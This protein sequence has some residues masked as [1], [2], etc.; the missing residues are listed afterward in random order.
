MRSKLFAP[1]VLLTLS[2]SL[3]ADDA[4]GKASVSVFGLTVQKPGSMDQIPFFNP[5]TTLDVVIGQPGKFILGIDAK[6]SKLT[7]F[8]DDK[9]T[10][11]TKTKSAFPRDW[12]N[13]SFLRFNK[14]NT[15]CAVQVCAPS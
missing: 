9:K 1:V 2:G 4:K 5:G 3:F 14:D 12:L 6:A 15:Q 13:A 8:T 10:D 11:L 7:A